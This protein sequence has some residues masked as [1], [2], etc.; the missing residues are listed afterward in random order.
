MDNCS[1]A[2]EKRIMDGQRA[3][4][5]A[6]VRPIS[7]GAAERLMRGLVQIP[8]PLGRAGPNGERPP[9]SAARPSFRWRVNCVD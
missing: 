9:R 7:P 3:E 4:F 8:E 1:E 5:I 2:W 6:A